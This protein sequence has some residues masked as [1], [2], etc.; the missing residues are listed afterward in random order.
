MFCLFIDDDSS[1]MVI[2]LLRNK[3][4]TTAAFKDYDRKL[5]NKTTRHISVLRS[6]GGTEFLNLSMKDYCQINGISQQSSTPYTP[7]QNGRAERPNRT[8]LE[9]LSAMLFDSQLS[10]EY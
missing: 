5:F 6:D 1:Y 9:G 8:V 7:Q 2:Y 10:W 4:D 3:S